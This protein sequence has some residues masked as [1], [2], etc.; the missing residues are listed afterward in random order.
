MANVELYVWLII[1]DTT[2]ITTF[3]TLEKM[4]FDIKS[5][6][7][8]DYYSFE[9]DESAGCSVKEFSKKIARVD[10]LVNANKHCFEVFAGEKEAEP[11]SDVVSILVEDFEKPEGLL[12]TLRKRLGFGEIKDMEKATLWE[13]E[14]NSKKTAGKITRELLCNENYQ[15]FRVL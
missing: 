12:N 8:K 11:G 15:G 14:V 10:I 4:G 13:L 5:V 9:V 2:A 1:P 6:K 7:R 3:H